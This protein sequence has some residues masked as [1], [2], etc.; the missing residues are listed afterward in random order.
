MEP[1]VDF[2]NLL[3]GLQYLPEREKII[4]V[5]LI[6]AQGMAQNGEVAKIERLVGQ[7]IIAAAREN[8]RGAHPETPAPETAPEGTPVVSRIR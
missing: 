4:L 3:T 1:V 7:T 5:A 6:N 2:G 8:H